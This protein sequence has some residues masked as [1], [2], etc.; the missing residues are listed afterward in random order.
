MVQPKSTEAVSSQDI[1]ET[2][3]GA[4]SQNP[5]TVQTSSKLL[6][7]YQDRPGTYDQLHIIAAERNTVP[8][9]VRRMAIIQFK[10]GALGNWKNRRLFTNDIRA[11]IRAR[12]MSFLYEEDN[13][14]ADCN[15]LIVAKIARSDFPAQ[16]PSLIPDLT[17]IVQTQIQVFLSNPTGADPANTLL[18]KRTLRVLDHVVKEFCAVK[19]PNGIR[20]MAQ[21][22]ESLYSPLI[23]HYDRLSTLLQA[24]LTAP[25]ILDPL[26]QGTC[27]E[28][29]EL[30]HLVFKPC[31]KIMLWLWQKAGQPQFSAVLETLSVFSQSCFQLTRNLFDLRIQL[32]LAL[33]RDTRTGSITSSSAPSSTAIPVPALKSLHQLTRH[34]RLYG[35]MFRRMQRLSIQRFVALPQAN[36]LVLYYWGEVVKATDGSSEMISDSPDAVYPIRLLVQGMVLF[37]ES[38]NIWSGKGNPQNM[39]KVLS[40]QFVEEAV[41]LL[42]TRFIPLS[43]ADLE[44][45][46]IEP[47]EW[48]NEEEKG[49]DSWEFELRPCGERVL[50]TLCHHYHAF[51]TS[52]LLKTFRQ[53]LGNPANSLTSI[54][55]KEAVYCAVGRCANWLNGQLDFDD[56]LNKHLILEAQESNPDYRVVKRRIAWVI[57]KWHADESTSTSKPQVWEVLQHLMHDRGPS[58]DPVVR[59]SAAEALREC[60]DSVQFDGQSFQPFLGGFVTELVRLIAEADTLESKNRLT[61]SLNIVI[62]RAEIR[63]VPLI[64]VIINP[65]PQLWAE[66]GEDYL[67]KASL[68]VTVTRLVEAT[69]EHS[70]VISHVVI[71]LIQESFT[72]KAK[73]FLDEDGLRLWVAALKNAL[74]LESTRSGAPALID[75]FPDATLLV[76]ENLDLLGT[77]LTIVES[78]LLLDGNRVLSTYGRE[79][80]Q[81]FG[82]AMSKAVKTNV[83]DILRALNLM[84]QIVPATV[85]AEPMHSSGLFAAL[86]KV[87]IEDKESALELTEHVY[88][89]ARI[90]LSDPLIF[91]HLVAGAAP[92]LNMPET[93]VFEG[94][95]DQWWAKFDNM[96]EPRHRKLAA[97]GI[98][99]WVS[100][101]RPEVLGRLHTEIFNLWLDVFG[102]LREALADGSVEGA[103]SPL[104][105]FWKNSVEEQPMLNGG[106]IDGSLETDRRRQVYRRD[107]VNTAK[108]T[109]FVKEKL[110]LAEAACGGIEIFRTN[111]LDKADPTVLGQI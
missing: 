93:Q 73:H 89:F 45:W 54:L 100:T 81:A 84:A 105:M 36:E 69:R 51:V 109:V 14:V 108:L 46:A 41:I 97:M 110:Q 76:S 92:A 96:A 31:A 24:S 11:N 57:G 35:K 77:I 26:L 67:L 63:I 82:S 75:M 64:D 111:Y 39:T 38:L 107:P 6:Q 102:E 91:N 95:L 2:L 10:N 4:A 43:P 18:F 78:Y 53:V 86:V 90:A 87:V 32:I 5:A 98:A 71:S 27:E 60:V 50:M 62:E 42:L 99:S 106:D 34:L 8:L 49:G 3:C 1:Y 28:V 30:C 101:A 13:T 85:W 9:D 70:G 66:A 52:L 68:I 80:F 74:T 61:K 29:V 23:S 20:T 55:Q 65:L 15:A 104:S 94:L 88:V 79:L 44:K 58:S 7:E 17:A 103:R 83:A 25:A 59:L 21:I 12:T 56:W 16:W 72:P 37:R 47:E 33:R 19:M 48:V 22:A 40:K